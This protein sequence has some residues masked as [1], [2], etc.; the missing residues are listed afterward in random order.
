MKALFLVIVLLTFSGCTTL[1]LRLFIND[2]RPNILASNPCQLP[3]FYNIV[4]NQ[5]TRAEAQVALAQN[6]S[7][8]Q[9][10]VLRNGNLFVCLDADC[11]TW[12]GVQVEPETGIVEEITIKLST[13]ANF[14]RD[15][16]P[17][18]DQP[19]LVFS[20]GDAFGNGDTT[21]IM[22]FDE[23]QQEV[24]LVQNEPALRIFWIESIYLRNTLAYNERRQALLESTNRHSLEDYVE[25]D[26]CPL[27][28]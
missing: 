20:L 24:V 26:F 7:A 1:P 14:C 17:I 19:S 11:T 21:L 4:V 27:S 25:A 15:Y 9:T 28:E 5:T 2:D 23:Q 6:F 22:L 10:E 13:Q 8:I 16:A 18:L 12:I 3:C